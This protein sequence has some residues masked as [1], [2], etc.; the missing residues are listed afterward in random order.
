LK[1]QAGVVARS[2]GDRIDTGAIKTMLRKG[3][4]GGI[5]NGCARS[6]GIARARWL[7][8]RQILERFL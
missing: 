7:V 4:F 6:L 2:L 5:Q 8:K 1:Q 3:R